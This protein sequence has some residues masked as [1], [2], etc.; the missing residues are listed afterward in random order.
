MSVPKIL[1]ADHG[2][3]SL[4]MTSE[5]VKDKFPGA[6]VIIADSGKQ[7]VELTKDKK[8]DICIID[9]DLPDA[10]GASLIA[11]MRTF[12]KGPILL[13]AYPDP[14]VELAVSAELFGYDDASSWVSKPVKMEV[15]AEKIDTFINKSYR[16]ETRFSGKVDAVVVGKSLGRGKKAPSIEGTMSNIS[17]NGL[18]IELDEKLVARKGDEISVTLLPPKP[19]GKAAG[20]S[21]AKNKASSAASGKGKTGTLAAQPK[22]KAAAPKEVSVRTTI[23]WISKDRSKVGLK[24]Q[25][26][27]DVQRKGI[28]SYLQDAAGFAAKPVA[29]PAEKKMEN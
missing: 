5:I 28:D 25:K 27:T 7:A 14:A 13:T 18:C 26:I 16:I 1:I 21:S 4:V 11:L 15:L 17:L 12:Y 29:Q 3:A 24:F 19:Q 6:V 23:A 10:D 2:K 9:F 20:K 22:S 8:P